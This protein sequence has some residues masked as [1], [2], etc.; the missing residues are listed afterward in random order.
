MAVRYSIMRLAPFVI[1]LLFSG[2]I[3][4]PTNTPDIVCDPPYM[5]YGESCCL[6]SNNNGICDRD[7]TQTTIPQ[8][9]TSTIEADKITETTVTTTITQ[10][11]VTTTTTETTVTTTTLP[12]I[13]VTTSTMQATTSTLVEQILDLFIPQAGL[14]KK[15]KLFC[16]DG[17]C[18]EGEDSNNC[19]LDCG[20]SIGQ[21]CEN[22]KCRMM[23]IPGLDAS[24][25][26][27]TMTAGDP[28]IV[29]MIDEVKVTDIDGLFI[30]FA[31][32]SAAKSG[33][34][35]Q[36]LKWPQHYYTWAFEN[37]ILFLG[38]LN[39]VPMFSLP[40]EEM[41][42]I[43]TLEMW[44][45][46]IVKYVPDCPCH[47]ATVQ[48]IS[49]EEK[50][51]LKLFCG[52]EE[53]GKF[54]EYHKKSDDWGVGQTFTKNLGR[55]TVKYSI[56]RVYLPRK[57]EVD[58]TLKKVT[59]HRNIWDSSIYV[60]TRVSDGFEPEAFGLNYE[61]TSHHKRYLAGGKEFNIGEGQTKTFDSE[62]LFSTQSLGPFLYVEALVG[63]GNPKYTFCSGG[64]VYKREVAEYGTLS[65]TWFVNELL[66][67][68]NKEKTI[69]VNERMS[70]PYGDYTIELEIKRKPY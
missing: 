30:P 57:L 25:F 20:C 46:Q 60:F 4:L 52:N 27:Q 2:C 33:G 61:H 38:D 67:D 68:K 45:A 23:T 65:K 37:Q 16:G 18:S 48:D 64:E 43:L 36:R 10:T 11:T 47:G 17:I 59:V 63:E 42:D 3:Q 22:N 70:G 14:D 51:G 39:A 58:V 15:F 55:A 41:G 44:L 29:V 34:E 26:M 1:L 53:L 49:F 56:K 6:D 7:E 31:M 54:M 21:I 24:T 40:E 8:K 50:F 12:E 9:T 62:L 35:L 32:A 66:D 5:R 13:T 69:T 19:C 28:Y